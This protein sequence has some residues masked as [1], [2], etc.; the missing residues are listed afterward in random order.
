M[1]R[2]NKN[3]N[4][5]TELFSNQNIHVNAAYLGTLSNIPCYLLEIRSLPP[6]DD[7][8]LSFPAARVGRLT[9]YAPLPKAGMFLLLV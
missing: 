1:K 8:L 6:N 7:T 3:P 5:L 4:M 2:C 9:T